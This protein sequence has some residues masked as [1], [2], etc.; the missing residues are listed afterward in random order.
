MDYA[1]SENL[2]TELFTNTSYFFKTSEME[3]CIDIFTSR[4]LKLTTVLKKRNKKSL[5]QF[6]QE[7]QF[8]KLTKMNNLKS[9]LII[10]NQRIQLVYTHISYNIHLIIYLLYSSY[11]IQLIQRNVMIETMNH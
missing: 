1:A 6:I 3:K 9:Y 11:V 7:I 8:V 2:E 10:S 5:F 4:I